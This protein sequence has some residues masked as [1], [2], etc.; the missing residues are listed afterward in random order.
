[1]KKTKTYIVDDAG[2]IKAVVLDYKYFKKLEELILD[3]GLA[4]AMEEVE[5]DEEIDL[6]EAK[7]IMKFESGS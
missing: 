5:D 3:L 6:E 4:K 7:K 1:M 2:N